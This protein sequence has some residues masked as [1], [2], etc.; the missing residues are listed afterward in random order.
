MR[1]STA[2]IGILL[3]LAFVPSHAF[4]DNTFAGNGT[5]ENNPWI[6]AGIWFVEGMAADSKGNVYLALISQNIVVRLDSDGTLTRIAGTGTFGYS[7]DNG[8]AGNAQLAHPSGVAVD[9]AGDLYIADSRNYRIR[10]VSNGTITTFAGNG[11]PVKL[12]FRDNCRA[13]DAHIAPSGVAIDPT[14][15]L[16]IAESE[17]HRVRK[18]SNGRITTVAGIG[19]YG[20]SGDNGPA[21]KAQLWN[22]R[23]IAVDSAGNLYI[24]ERKGVR[25]VSNGV[26][27]TIAGDYT[28]QGYSGDN[29]PAINA[30][31]GQVEDIAVD[32]VGNLYIADTMYHCVR[33]V[34]DGMIATIAGNGAP[35]FGGDNG[36]A[37]DAQLHSPMSVAVDSVGNLYIADHSNRRIRKVSNGIITSLPVK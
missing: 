2:L 25:S 34:S 15:N 35:G 30:T 10:K 36:P 26:I 16:Y 31:F 29:G 7:G 18:V 11:K 8:P 4:S 17:G 6:S 21:K 3:F 28:R 13:T 14:G 1:N 33:K 22:P 12:F 27:V 24:A 37:V 9:S 20:Y 5:F 32:S 23:G 19:R